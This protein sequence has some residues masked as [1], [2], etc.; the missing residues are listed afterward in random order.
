[1]RDQ[2]NGDICN[3]LSNLLRDL[4]ERV[5]GQLKQLDRG[6]IHV[7]VGSSAS[8]GGTVKY[9]EVLETQLADID[10]MFSLLVAAFL[11]RVSDQA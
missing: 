8:S 1:M 11:Q 2:V 9:R 3:E 6:E 10:D 5:Q 4:R 7:I